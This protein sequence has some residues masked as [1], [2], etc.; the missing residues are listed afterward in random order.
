VAGKLAAHAIFSGIAISAYEL[1]QR[2]LLLPRPKERTDRLWDGAEPVLDMPAEDDLRW[3]LAVLGCEV[4]DRGVLERVV[5]AV[6]SA[7]PY[8]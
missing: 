5:R 4:N 8:T 1:K 6:R 2:Y 3:G 7:A